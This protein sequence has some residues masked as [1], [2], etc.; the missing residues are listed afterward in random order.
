MTRKSF[1]SS[2][3]FDFPSLHP[4]PSI[5]LTLD[6]GPRYQD[7]ILPLYLSQYFVQIFDWL[8]GS[9]QGLQRRYELVHIPKKKNNINTSLRIAESRN[10]LLPSMMWTLT[11][12]L[13][14]NIS[15][16]FNA[17]CSTLTRRSD[18]GDVILLPEVTI[19]QFKS[20][21]RVW[22]ISEYSE[23]GVPFT[24][25]GEDRGAWRIHMEGKQHTDRG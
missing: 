16:I 5:V 20:V 13:P 22:N 23:V 12:E 15:N 7:A 10:A 3:W 11:W 9:Y 6:L 4:E 14:E 8:Q 21:N 19:C 18:F 17:L 2:L 24:G 1:S 25:L